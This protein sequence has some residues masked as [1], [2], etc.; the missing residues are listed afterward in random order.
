[1]AGTDQIVPQ[2]IVQIDPLEHEQMGGKY[3]TVTA[4]STGGLVFG[5]FTLKLTTRIV[6][7]G[8]VAVP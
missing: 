8:S 7:A 3:M 5:Y 2:D 1:M 6:S 4:V